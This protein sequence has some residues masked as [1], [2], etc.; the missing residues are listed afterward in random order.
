MPTKDGYQQCYNPQAG[1]DA[2]AQIIVACS[3]GNSS[4]DCPQLLPTVDQIKENLGRKPKCCS[5]DAGYASE[6]NLEGLATRKITAYIATGR[7]KHGTKTATNPKHGKPGSLLA[8]MRD[9]LKRGGWRSPYRLRKQIVEPVFGQI[10]A[11][12]GFRQ[13]LLRG[14]AQV[15]EEWRLVAT[16]H[17]LLK[18]MRASA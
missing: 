16:A 11:A 9:R 18:L 1:V 13:F 8:K 12:M 14:L 3:V 15:Q 2:R 17:N 6:A 7:Q 5:A 4:A 10:K